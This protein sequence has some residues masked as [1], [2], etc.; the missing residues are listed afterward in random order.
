MKM[1]ENISVTEK[2][3]LI[4]FP[5]YITLLAAN[6]GGELNDSEKKSAFKLS[7]IK[8]FSSDPLLYEFYE[9]ADKDFNKNIE[10]LDKHLPEDKENRDVAIKKELLNVESIVLKLGNDYTATM[11]RSMKSFKDH[12]SKVHRNVLED[13]LFPILI[14]GLTDQIVE[15]NKQNKIIANE[16]NQIDESRIV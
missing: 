5:A 1:F 15:E 2:E 16:Y 11:Q 10:Y 13:F 9:L 6:K 7:H 14:D 3:E 4:K 12:V 8:T